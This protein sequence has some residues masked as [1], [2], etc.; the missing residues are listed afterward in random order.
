MP[1]TAKDAYGASAASTG[2]VY[3]PL[4]PPSPP[5]PSFPQGGTTGNGVSEPLSV[6]SVPTPLSVV[7][8]AAASAPLSVAKG[9]TCRAGEALDPHPTATNVSVLTRSA[10]ARTR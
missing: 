3:V 2:T 1:F 4:T 8:R 6:A 5:G 9:D 7:G 10:G